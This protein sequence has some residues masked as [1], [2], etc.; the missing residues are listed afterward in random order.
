[1]IRDDEHWLAVTDAFHEAAIDG[2]GWYGALEGLA[3]ASGSQTGELIGIGVDAAIPINIMTNIDPGFHKAFAQ[4]RGG[5]PRV[6][7]RVRAGMAAPV[8]KVMAECDFITADE[9]KR[10]PHY[11]EFAR[12]WDIPFIC[13]ATLERQHG[14]LIGLAVVRSQRQ[15]HI[16]QPQREAFTTI[17]PHVR[18][19]VRTHIALEGQGAAI[20]SGTM[21]AL[22]IPAFVCDRLGLVRALTP[23]AEALV[24]SACGLQLRLGRLQATLPADA[25][26]L[27][28]AI[29]A[30]AIGYTQPRSPLP[31]TIVV[32]T[33]EQDM[34]PLALDVIP[35]QA[36]QHEFSFAPR[37]MIVARGQR[38]TQERRSAILQ[39]AYALTAAET[40]IA[41][42]IAAGKTADA[43]AKQ[44]SVA[45]G[46]VR[47]QIKSIFAKVG[48]NRQIELI[49]R[50]TQL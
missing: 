9:Y 38:G 20:L 7:P 49:A 35:L 48:V 17:A 34:A 11:Q 1:M 12:P 15:G 44:R 24:S 6:N 8:L 33:N 41:L 10:D 18:A 16:T 28:D 27:N 47:L 5:D 13:L 46:T 26:R 42:Q 50:L 25:Q 31:R 32:R 22:S 4:A 19:A 23:A 43:I 45:I 29:N 37:V 21:E 40:D 39:A 14:M 3:Q 2:N 36:R 30:A